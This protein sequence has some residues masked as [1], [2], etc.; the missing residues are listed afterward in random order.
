VA[1]AKSF[2]PEPVQQIVEQIGLSL[3]L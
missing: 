1:I 3:S 2:A